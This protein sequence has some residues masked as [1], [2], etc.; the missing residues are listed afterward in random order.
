MVPFFGSKIRGA[1]SDNQISQSILDFKQGNGSQQFKKAESAPLFAPEDNMNNSY[2]M[3][4][5]S[6]FFQSRMNPGNNMSNITLWE[7]EKVAPGLNLDYSCKNNNTGFNSGMEAREIWQPKTV[8][9]LRVETNPKLSY[10]LNGHQGPANNNIKNLGKIGK[11]EKYLPE[12]FYNNDSSRWLTTTGVQKGETKRGELILNDQNR[13]NTTIEYF[14]NGKDSLN[15][16]YAEQNFEDC[17][18]I[19][20]EGLPI[21]NVSAAGYGN[22][23]IKP[24]FSNYKNNRSTTQNQLDFGPVGGLAKAIITPIMD[25]IRPTRKENVIGNL[26][27]SGNFQN[28]NGNGYLLNK[29]DTL[30]VTNRQIYAESKNH[31]NI[32]GQDSTGYLVSNPE[33]LGNQRDSTC[34]DYTANGGGATHMGFK[35]NEAANNQHNNVNKTYKSRPNQGGTQIFNQQMNIDTYKNENDRNNNRMWVPTNAP[36]NYNNTILAADNARGLQTYDQ[37]INN[38]RLNPDLLSAFKNNPYTHSLQ[39]VA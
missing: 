23:D 33:I 30:P 19:N 36:K 1:T 38:D 10:D 13:Q 17:K 24:S 31:L 16:T 9:Q 27:Q 22:N 4:N 35:S 20:L 15:S 5:N 18:K 12:K 7:Q 14:G 6:D 37:K 34:T 8:D 2:G 39:S 21:S 26:R 25:I 11:V 32:Q 28:S 3:K 29:N